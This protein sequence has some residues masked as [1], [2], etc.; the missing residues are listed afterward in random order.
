MWRSTSKIEDQAFD[1]AIMVLIEHRSVCIAFLNPEYNY[2]G[3]I[4]P[5]SYMY[6]QLFERIYRPV[7][8]MLLLH[9]T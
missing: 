6:A 2:F 7:L 4:K 8:S 9:L 5:H 3:I 1:V